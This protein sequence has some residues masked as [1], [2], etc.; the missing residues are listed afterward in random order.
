MAYGDASFGRGQTMREPTDCIGDL[1]RSTADSVWD[2]YTA[3][4]SLTGSTK[5]QIFMRLFLI[6]EGYYVD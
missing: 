1:L 3:A 6:K 2:I 5:I 4:D